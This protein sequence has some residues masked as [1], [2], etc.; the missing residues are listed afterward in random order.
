MLS[1][2]LNININIGINSYII[3]NSYI[4]IAIYKKFIYLFI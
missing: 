4:S 2:I 3:F 1:V